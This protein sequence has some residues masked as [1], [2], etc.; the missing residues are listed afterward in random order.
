MQANIEIVGLGSGDMEQLPLGVYRTLE[1]TEKVIYTR[2]LDHPVIEEVIEEG[3]RFQSLEQIYEANGDAESV[4]ETIVNNLLEIGNTE[5]IIYTVPGHP[6]VAEK[7]VQRLLA[8]K[9]TKINISGG[10]SYLDAMFT[11][12]QIDPIEGLQF[13]DANAF[14]RSEISYQQHMIF[15]QV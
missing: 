11:T 12:L 8:N 1:Q 4:Y 2:T 9:S 5:P 6:L 7:T 10:Q 3:D 15:C 14:D 13:M